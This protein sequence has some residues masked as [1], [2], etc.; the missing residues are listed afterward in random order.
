MT[1]VEDA[2]TTEEVLV[3]GEVSVAKEEV[4]VVAVFAAIEVQ[5]Q[6]AVVLDQEK[7]AV[8]LTEHLVKA[9]SAEEANQEVHQLQEEKVVFLPNAHLAVQMHLDQADFL[10]ELQDAPKVLQIHQEK[11]DQERANSFC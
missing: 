5:H 6:E 8:F 9:V 7:K 11:E 2:I 4:L 10:K 1:E 3:A